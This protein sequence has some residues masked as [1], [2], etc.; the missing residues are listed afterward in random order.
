MVYNRGNR[1]H[2]DEWDYHYGCRGWNYNNI[3]QYFLR[4]EGN[5]DTNYLR[6]NPRYHNNS[7]PLTVS[8]DWPHLN[9]LPIF[10]TFLETTAL[11]GFPVID[12]NGMQK[13]YLQFSSV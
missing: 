12:I 13:N 7:G 8:S 9:V 10:K 1:R 5:T 3:L 11:A 2:F 4:S 6:Q